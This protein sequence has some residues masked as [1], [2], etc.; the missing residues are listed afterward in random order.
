MC[1]G[2]TGREG[3][4][5]QLLGTVISPI[6]MEAH[7]SSTLSTQRRREHISPEFVLKLQF[8]LYNYAYTFITVKLMLHQYR[9]TP[10]SGFG[11]RTPASDSGSGRRVRRISLDFTQSQLYTPH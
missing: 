4:I 5:I 10:Y 11:L 2:Y 3:C 6:N 7:A 9:R 8:I 1:S